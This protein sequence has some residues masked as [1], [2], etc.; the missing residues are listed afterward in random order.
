MTDSSILTGER[1]F[2]RLSRSQ[3]TQHI[4]MMISFFLLVLTGLPLRYDDAAWAHHLIGFLGGFTA[5]SVLHRISAVILML[6]CTYHVGWTVFT[7]RGHRELMALIPKPKDL[8]DVIHMLGYYFGLKRDKPKFD[9]FNFI[10]KFEYLALAWGSAVMILTG[11]ILWFE[12]QAMLVLPKWSLDIGLVVHS[13]EAVLAFLAIII[14]H[15]YHVHL[16][17]EVFPM[18]RIWLTG[19]ISEHE[20]KEHHPLEYERIV[21]NERK[22]DDRELIET[23]R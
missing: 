19:E 4:F 16:N 6:V 1:R 18:S 12:E 15:F 23:E 10:E 2:E 3:R 22:A 8:F 20:M 7:N 11:L 14:W 13:Y 5:R 17:P 9:R 21:G